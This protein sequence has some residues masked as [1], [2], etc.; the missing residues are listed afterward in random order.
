MSKLFVVPP[1]DQVGA[2]RLVSQSGKVLPFKSLLSLSHWLTNRVGRRRASYRN[3]DLNIGPA[4]RVCVERPWLDQP[5]YRHYDWVLETVRGHRLDPEVIPVP[6]WISAWRRARDLPMGQYRCD[7]VPHTRGSRRSRQSDYLRY[8]KTQAERR[9][10]GGGPVDEFEPA[11]RSARS[12][13]YLPTAWDDQIRC[14][15][16]SW[17]SHRRTQWKTVQSEEV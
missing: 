6:E 17:K 4:F 5:Y 10:A 13:R 1:A 16:R 15:Q 12:R 11:P 14:N 8:P 9:L 3:W 2:V 7:P